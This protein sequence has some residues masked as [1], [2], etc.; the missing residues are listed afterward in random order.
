MSGSEETQFNFSLH[1]DASPMA[2]SSPKQTL[3]SRAMLT[4]DTDSVSV[5]VTD[6]IDLSQ[7]E[8]EETG[9]TS[10]DFIAH[11]SQQR[12]KAKKRKKSN[13]SNAK[14]TGTA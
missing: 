12:K 3:R 10:L 2:S 9:T 11:G 4:A 6:S 7:Q 8:S 13:D 5:N 1:S 14:D